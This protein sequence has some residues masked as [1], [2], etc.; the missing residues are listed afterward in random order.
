MSLHCRYRRTVLES[1]D[2]SA[3][4][5]GRC[6]PAAGALPHMAGQ[7]GGRNTPY[8]SPAHPAFCTLHSAFCIL[9]PEP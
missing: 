2:D 8:A 4:S 3:L 5:T 6:V 1:V 7:P 9:N